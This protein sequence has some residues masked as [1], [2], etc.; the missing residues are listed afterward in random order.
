MTLWIRK[1]RYSM[2]CPICG[3]ERFYVKNPEDAYE[4]LEFDVKKGEVIFPS[5][6]A[7]S[8]CLDVQDETETYCDNCSWHGKLKEIK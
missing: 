6:E 3:C 8:D 2:P 4:T 1:E 5:E 7:E